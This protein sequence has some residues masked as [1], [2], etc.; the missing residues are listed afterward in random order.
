VTERCSLHQGP[1]QMRDMR[2]AGAASLLPECLLPVYKQR[3]LATC[4]ERRHETE[5]LR[6]RIPAGSKINFTAR[7]RCYYCDQPE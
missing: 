3:P 6:A 4:P 7:D 5:I 2:H 1:I